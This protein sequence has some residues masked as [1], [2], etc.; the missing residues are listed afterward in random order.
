MTHQE[1]KLALG[2]PL[3][4]IDTGFDPDHGSSKYAESH[5]MP[6]KTRNHRK[7]RAPKGEDLSH[8]NAPNTQK[9]QNLGRAGGKKRAKR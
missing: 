6:G 7:V 8:L 5:Y 9:M 3:T 1:K 2:L 4:A